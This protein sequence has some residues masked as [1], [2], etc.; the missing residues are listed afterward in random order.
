MATTSIRTLGA[1][2]FGATLAAALAG[3]ARHVDDAA[4]AVRAEVQDCGPGEVGGGE[5]VHAELAL[6]GRLPVGEGRI[7]RGLGADAGIVDEAVQSAGLRLR[8]LP[9]RGGAGGVG[10]VGGKDEAAAAG[11][12]TQGIIGVVV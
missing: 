12:A 8:R 9:E 1:A 4:A 3:P 11:L 2:A 6:P 5:E 7:N 10:K